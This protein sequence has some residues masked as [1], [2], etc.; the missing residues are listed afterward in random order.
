MPE[1]KYHYYTFESLSSCGLTF[2][3]E[4]QDFQSYTPLRNL[5]LRVNII[6][7][8]LTSIL[9]IIQMASKIIFSFFGALF[10]LFA[11]FQWNDPDS[12]KWILYYLLIAGM[13]FATAFN[14]NKKLYLYLILGITLVWMIT[15]LPGAV[16]WMKD[17]M[18][19][20]VDSMKASSP[21]IELVREF[22]GLLIS[23]VM[24]GSLLLFEIKRKK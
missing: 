16:D 5:A 8:S 6:T 14:S 20:I 23:F 3:E 19:S 18:P 15:L 22:L 7:V 4:S 1:N 21:Y 12:L 13:S 2:F 17:G 10:L 24:L 11:Y 9:K